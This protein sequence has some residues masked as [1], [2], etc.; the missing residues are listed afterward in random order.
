MTAP[1]ITSA[2]SEVVEI[3]ILPITDRLDNITDILIVSLVVMGM[4]L[5]SLVFR[6]F[7]K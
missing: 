1:D 7:R 5:G 6:H 2:L 3:D 4:I